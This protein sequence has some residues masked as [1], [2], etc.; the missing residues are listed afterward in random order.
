MNAIRKRRRRKRRKAEKQ[1]TML[2]ETSLRVKELERLLKAQL[3]LGNL[4]FRP[5]AEADSVKFERWCIASRVG[6]ERERKHRLQQIR[7]VEG[8]MKEVIA[9]LEYDLEYQ[10]QQDKG[11]VDKCVLLVDRMQALQK[12]EMR[13]RGKGA[14][15]RTETIPP[16]L[17]QQIA[18][19]LSNRPLGS[20][21][22]EG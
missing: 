13:S 22:S 6:I 3:G 5:P 11:Y 4:T 7:L 12:A 14:L 20:Y 18:A 9:A 10:Y 21:A 15:K 16:E 8:K 1:R 19:Y 17:R 2:E